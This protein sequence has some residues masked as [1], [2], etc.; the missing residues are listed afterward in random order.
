MRD[1][2]VRTQ[3]RITTNLS[4]LVDPTQGKAVSSA[5]SNVHGTKPSMLVA[6]ATLQSLNCPTMQA[7]EDWLDDQG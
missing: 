3:P 7:R 5:S 2:F 4:R 1:W 6:Q